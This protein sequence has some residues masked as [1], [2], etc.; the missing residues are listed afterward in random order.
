MSGMRG[1]LHARREAALSGSG[2]VP[3]YQ[4]RS[5]RCRSRRLVDYRPEPVAR[6][7]LRMGSSAGD[8]QGVRQAVAPQDHRSRSIARTNEK[9]GRLV[10]SLNTVER[11]ARWMHD[12]YGEWR[13]RCGDEPRP[14]E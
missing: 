3:D 13:I 7:H 11:L 8:V 14:W 5:L 2:R 6:L 9:G 4:M 1:G 10:A 12:A